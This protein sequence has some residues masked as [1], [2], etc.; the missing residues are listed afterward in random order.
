M[1][2]SINKSINIGEINNIS[3][4]KRFFN[5][6]SAQ[7]EKRLSKYERAANTYLQIASKQKF[8]EKDLTISKIYKEVLKKR[9]ETREAFSAV[10]SIFK[11]IPRIIPE[12]FGLTEEQAS[13]TSILANQIE[14]ASKK[15]HEIN[16]NFLTQVA[17]LTENGILFLTKRAAEPKETL[18][19]EG[20]LDND[21]K[22]NSPKE[23]PISINDDFVDLDSIFH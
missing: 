5:R 14:D 20:K 9:E 4:T 22:T 10:F 19:R 8:S 17:E 21:C 1:A 13:I 18:R 7:F 16:M 11:N 15:F 3:D 6:A 12:N 23:K 2:S